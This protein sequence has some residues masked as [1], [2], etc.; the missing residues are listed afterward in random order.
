MRRTLL[1]LRLLAMAFLPLLISCGKRKAPY[2]TMNGTAF[3]TTYRIIYRSEEDLMEEIQATMKSFGESLNNFDSLS[4][5]S[6]VNRNETHLADSLLARVILTAQAVS[7]ATGG[8]YDITGSPYF[9]AW[10]FGTKGKIRHAPTPEQLDSLRQYVGYDK[11]SI[12]ED[13]IVHKADPR[14]TVHAVSLS[15]GYLSDLIGHT[16]E[17]HGVSDY[18]VEFGGELVCRGQNAQGSCWRVGINRPVEDSTS[19]IQEIRYILSICDRGALA[20]SGDYRNF[21]FVDGKK[22]AHT[23]DAGTGMPANQN[24]LSATVKAPTCI[25]ADA[26]ATAFMGLGLQRAIEVLRD[27]PRLEVLFIYV[28]EEN[29]ISTY[30]KGL[31]PVEAP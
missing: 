30:T 28:D 29:K 16:L 20:T 13:S 12:R 6:R 22:V 26:W 25:E 18:M 2:I 9:E 4:L 21:T 24:I 10:G 5:I 27:Q 1:L 17:R 23:I 15:K 7:R 3:H 8:V 19:T 31:S 14:V 11:I